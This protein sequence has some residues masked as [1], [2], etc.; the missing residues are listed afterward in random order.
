MLQHVLRVELT[1]LAVARVVGVG[2]VA[3]RGLARHELTGPTRVE[4]LEVARLP[5][6]GRA[7]GP[8][9]LGLV[10][11][12]VDAVVGDGQGVLAVDPHAE[13][14]GPGLVRGHGPGPHEGLE[15][16]TALGV[17]EDVLGVLDRGLRLRPRR[18]TQR[19][20]PAVGAPHAVVVVGG[21]RLLVVVGGDGSG[22]VGVAG[23]GDLGVAEEVV[24]QAG[25]PVGEHLVLVGRHGLA[26]EQVAGVGVVAGVG[27]APG[28]V[29]EVL[30]EGLVLGHDVIDVLDGRAS[31]RAHGRRGAQS[32]AARV[33]GGVEAVVVDHL[34][35][36][37]AEAAGVDVD[38][39]DGAAAL[40]SVR[41]HRSVYARPRTFAL[42][43]GHP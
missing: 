22:R 26:V 5:V 27:H 38:A 28:Q 41:E 35:R 6:D 12:H 17:V 29:P 7:V 11:R 33:E 40:V 32:H 24:T 14:P 23:H 13:L 43:V 15:E 39:A 3:T 8:G 1:G 36:P 2:R 10:G 4:V 34:L 16:I 9:P 42:G 30:V 20:T 19:V 25:H 18:R 31:R 37:G 21:P